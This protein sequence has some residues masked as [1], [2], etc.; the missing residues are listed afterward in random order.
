MN[1]QQAIEAIIFAVT[2]GLMF[3][4]HYVI[5]TLIKEHSDDYLAFAAQRLPAGQITSYLHSEIAKIIGRTG[6]ATQAG[7]QSLSYTIHGTASP[8]AL[9]QRV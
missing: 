1:I 4:S 2:P 6:F 3:D 9:W 7:V 8:C 5:D